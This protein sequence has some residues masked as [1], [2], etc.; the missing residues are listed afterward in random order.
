MRP[1]PTRTGQHRHWR[2]RLIPRHSE[3]SRVGRRTPQGLTLCTSGARLGV[4]RVCDE[5]TRRR[6]KYCATASAQRARRGTVSSPRAQA[7]ASTNHQAR[8]L[9]I[10]DGRGT[11]A[12]AQLADGAAVGSPWP[13]G[14]RSSHALWRARATRLRLY[15]SW[16][17]RGRIAAR[18]G[19]PAPAPSLLSCLQ[20]ARS[21]LASGLGPTQFAGQTGLSSPDGQ[22][23]C[24]HRCNRAGWIRS[25]AANT[26]LVTVDEVF[27]SVPADVHVNPSANTL[28]LPDWRSG[29]P[30]RPPVHER[31][32]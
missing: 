13:V 19:A 11:P 16:R 17:P 32:P 14:R 1:N 12:P 24:E 29:A 15:R 28:R 31:G 6:A 9:P 8:R 7:S 20:V 2:A 25:D 21:R 23:R 10:R 4:L 22:R 3:P 5:T 18:A 30:R 26:D 27:G